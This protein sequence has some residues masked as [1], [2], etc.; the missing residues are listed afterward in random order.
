MHLGGV[1]G[2]NTL[3]INPF[4]L[5]HTYQIQQQFQERN[6]KEVQDDKEREYKGNT[7]PMSLQLKISAGAEI[8]LIP[9]HPPCPIKLSD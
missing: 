9:L 5:R 4:L 2:S 8:C 1:P 7:L 3:E 6:K